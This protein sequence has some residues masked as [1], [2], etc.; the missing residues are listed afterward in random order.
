M[1]R[2]NPEDALHRS[3]A[4]LL[5]RVLRKPT[6]WTT[7]GHGGG[8]KV[9]GAQL[10][11]KGVQSGWSDIIVL[12]PAKYWTIALG[13]ELKSKDG[14]ASADQLQHRN[15]MVAVNGHWHLCRSLDDVFAALNLAGIPCFGR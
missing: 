3:V 4:Q 6:I 12:H 10:K 7:I 13:L 8:G 9:R 14:R 2:T 15:G 1:T 11:A 5:A